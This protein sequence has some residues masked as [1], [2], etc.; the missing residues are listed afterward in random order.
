MEAKFGRKYDDEEEEVL[1][2]P[3]RK[4]TNGLLRLHISSKGKNINYVM[5]KLDAR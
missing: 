5:E 4:Q 3:L 2:C 1:K